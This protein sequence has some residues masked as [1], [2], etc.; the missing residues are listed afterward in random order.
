MAGA[1]QESSRN[2]ASLA[3]GIAIKILRQEQVIKINE[4]A[5]GSY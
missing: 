2:S 3:R 4:R 1:S 5:H